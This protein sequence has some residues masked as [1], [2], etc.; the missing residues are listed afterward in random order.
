MSLQAILSILDLPHSD[1]AAA[2]DG[3]GEASYIRQIPP[4][5]IAF[6]PFLLWRRLGL[7]DAILKFLQPPI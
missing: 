2:W 3:L 5:A 7:V 4:E 1:I 6:I